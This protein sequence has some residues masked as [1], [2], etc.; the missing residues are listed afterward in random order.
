MCDVRSLSMGGP[1]FRRHPLAAGLVATGLVLAI[2]WCRF[3]L[4]DERD[5]TTL[6]Y[7]LPVTLVGMTFGRRAGTLAAVGCVALLSAWLMVADVALSPVGWAARVIPVLLLGGLIGAASDALEAAAKARVEL[8]VAAA[9]Q[10][11]A[12]EVQDEILQRLVAAKWKAEAAGAEGAADLL[13]DAIVAG[14][15]VVQ[16]LLVESTDPLVSRLPLP[17]PAAPDPVLAPHD[18]S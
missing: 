12:A 2:T 5:A 8:A 15:A 18:G 13:E 3:S 10:R 14:Q 1:W 11:D 6:L 9:R 7:A 17:P 4:G 16:D